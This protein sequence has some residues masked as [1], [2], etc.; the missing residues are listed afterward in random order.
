MKTIEK[1]KAIIAYKIFNFK[2]QC[3]NF[4]FEIGKEY[5]EENINICNSGF[6]SCLNPFD[7]LEYYDIIDTRF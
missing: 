7:I 3:R 6:H 2:L 1:E 4:Q 5:F